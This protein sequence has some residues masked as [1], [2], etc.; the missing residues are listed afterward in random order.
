MSARLVC[1]QSVERLPRRRLGLSQSAV[2]RVYTC[3]AQLCNSPVC[4]T[5]QG[6]ES[7]DADW[8]VLPGHV[9]SFHRVARSLCRLSISVFAAA[10]RGPSAGYAS[11]A[12][13]VFIPAVLSSVALVVCCVCCCCLRCC[14]PVCCLTTQ[15]E[16]QSLLN[17]AAP[18]S[19]THQ[20]QRNT[21]AH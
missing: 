18:G 16:H 5:G 2:E 13:S 20:S 8:L 21:P 3:R 10:S 15:R 4:S 19:T 6:A 17:A 14:P 9:Q 11:L 1:S 7:D 12:W